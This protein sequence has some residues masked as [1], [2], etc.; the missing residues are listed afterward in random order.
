IEVL[1]QSESV[2]RVVL[3]GPAEV[4]E[5]ES[6]RSAD[7]ALEEGASGPENL[8]RGLG[9]LQEAGGERPGHVLTT[10]LPFLT[11]A[12]LD[13]LLGAGPAAWP[14][15]YCAVSLPAAYGIRDRA[16]VRP[17]PAL[18]RPR[19]PRLRAG[20]GIRHRPPFRVSLCGPTPRPGAHARVSW[21]PGLSQPQLSTG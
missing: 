1:S 11:A 18:P 2:E 14:R 4:L 10:D 16:T 6:A 20:A 19:D 5:H 15:L 13:G 3:M 9:W 8:F 17:D 21:Q 12:A 7:A